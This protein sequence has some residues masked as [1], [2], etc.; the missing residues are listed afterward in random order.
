[1][2]PD[3]KPQHRETLGTAPLSQRQWVGRKEAWTDSQGGKGCVVGD[4][5][6][7]VRAGRPGQRQAGK[8]TGPGG[9]ARE[10]AGGVHLNILTPTRKSVQ[11]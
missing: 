10:R 4:A 3:S 8:G 6:I 5:G 9:R 11:L 1:M 2:S 7:E